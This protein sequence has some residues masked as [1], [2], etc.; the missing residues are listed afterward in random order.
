ML[1][2][3]LQLRGPVS[4]QI[5]KDELTLTSS[6]WKMIDEICSVLRPIKAISETLTASKYTTMGLVYPMIRILLDRNL[7]EQNNPSLSEVIKHFKQR[8]KSKLELDVGNSNAEPLMMVCSYIDPRFKSQMDMS[9]VQQQECSKHFKKHATAIRNDT[10]TEISF[11]PASVAT[12]EVLPASLALRK[13]QREEDEEEEYVSPAK[14]RMALIFGPNYKKMGTPKRAKKK[15][16]KL[17]IEIEE[18]EDEQEIDDEEDPLQ[19]WKDNQNKYPLLSLMA[20]K[21]L[22]TPATS[23]PSER[24]FSIA[25]QILTKKRARL[26]P[27]NA[28]MYVFMRAYYSL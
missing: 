16:D 14:K 4:G 1:E 28:E 23:V 11:K 21:Y 18:Y 7:D 2:R 5:Q 3:L 6:E 8:I 9:H 24:L 12:Q 19:W 15:K 10:E 17:L 22:G 26:S 25:G 13:Q 27:N 20:K